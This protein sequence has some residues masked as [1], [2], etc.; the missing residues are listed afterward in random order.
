[1]YSIQYLEKNDVIEP[2]DY[3]RPLD[4]EY[5]G[6]SDVLLTSSTYSGFPINHTRWLQVSRAG[7]SYFV[8]K[9]VGEYNDALYKMNKPHQR[10]SLYEFVRGN[11]PK[12]AILP[13]TEKEERV[14]LGRKYMNHVMNVGKYKGKTYHEVYEY[15]KSY[16][17][18]AQHEGI[19]P[20]FDP[21]IMCYIKQGHYD[22]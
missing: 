14:R 6:Q 2:T 10:V 21:S 19:I 12:D 4:L 13:E 9:T 11:I 18:W 20:H 16:F 3:C 15:D 5:I 7:I 17:D 8:G 22:K 1:M